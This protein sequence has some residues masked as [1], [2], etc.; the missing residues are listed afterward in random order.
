MYLPI[1]NPSLYSQPIYSF[2]HTGHLPEEGGNLQG[3]HAL[4]REQNH[5]RVLFGGRHEEEGK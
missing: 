1:T 5:W 2:S 4:P 3:V